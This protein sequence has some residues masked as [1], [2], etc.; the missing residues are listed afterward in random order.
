MF[1]CFLLTPACFLTLFFEFVTFVCCLTPKY[2]KMALKSSKGGRKVIPSGA[3]RGKSPLKM[4]Q[5]GALGVT[6]APLGGPWGLLGAARARY[7]VFGRFW[8]TF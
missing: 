3:Q 5:N 1:F 8:T 7:L 6:W 4:V 2:P